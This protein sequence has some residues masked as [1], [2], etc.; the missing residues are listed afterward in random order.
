MRRSVAD[1]LI[2]ALDTD[3]LSDALRL[4]KRLQGLIRYVKIGSTLF[5]AAGPL[6]IARMRARGLEVLLDL[7]F[8]DIPSTVEYSCRAAVRHRVAML[9]VHASGQREMLEAAA[10][11]VRREARRL[12]IAHPKVLGVTVLTSVN[13]THRQQMTA[14][15]LELAAQAKGAGLDGVVCSVQEAQVVRR[16]LGTSCVIVCPGIRPRGTE[17]SDQHRIAS[18]QEAMA[19]GADFLVV[20][21]PITQASD[22]RA[23]TQQI[24]QEMERA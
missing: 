21:R 19:H 6:A 4:V 8:H 11:G 12:Q 18:P 20:G 7:K 14:H 2:V 3:E 23:M 15:V 1:R 24:L 5:T 9:T 10:A 13:A 16:R 17:R 22:P